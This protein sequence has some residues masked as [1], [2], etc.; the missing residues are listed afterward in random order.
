MAHLEELRKITIDSWYFCRAVHFRSL[1]F[2]KEARGRISME[3][4]TTSLEEWRKSVAS[5]R[6]SLFRSRRY[7]RCGLLLGRAIIIVSPASEPRCSLPHTPTAPVCA[8]SCLYNYLVVEEGREGAWSSGVW[9][10]D[11][12]GWWECEKALGGLRYSDSQAKCWTSGSREPLVPVKEVQA[13]QAMAAR[14][15]H[16]GQEVRAKDLS[17]LSA[18]KQCGLTTS[19]S[20]IQAIWVP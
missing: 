2:S 18:S 17:Q 5:W 6:V 16:M 8:H 4:S 9:D 19:N 13:S 3:P 12:Q 11:G 15:H 14:K 1:P 10:R 7:P 20:G